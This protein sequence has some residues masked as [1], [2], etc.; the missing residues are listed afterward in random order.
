MKMM[1]MNMITKVNK[2][3]GTSGNHQELILGIPNSILTMNDS[4][5]SDTSGNHQELILN[6]LI[7]LVVKEIY[8]N[9]QIAKQVVKHHPEVIHVAP[10]LQCSIV[11][12]EY[13]YLSKLYLQILPF[14]LIHPGLGV[15]LLILL[16]L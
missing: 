10:V 1:A 6:I 15:D 4:K 2:N 3:F 8:Q 14:R 9:H 5:N 12:M 13:L 11:Q 7:I 16:H